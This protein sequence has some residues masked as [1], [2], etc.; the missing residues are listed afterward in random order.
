MASNVKLQRDCLGAEKYKRGHETDRRNNAK[1]KNKYE[2]RKLISPSQKSDQPAAFQASSNATS[3]VLLFVSGL[4]LQA[5][6]L[7]L[8]HG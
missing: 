3:L 4:F 2:E 7:T 8:L 1:L 6:T 5:L